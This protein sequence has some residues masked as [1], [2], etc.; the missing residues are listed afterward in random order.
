MCPLE[1]VSTLFLGPSAVD[2]LGLSVV[3]LLYALGAARSA[4][5]G[6]RSFAP[7]A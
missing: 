6:G 1:P 7:A 5:G 3:L 4:F 2:F